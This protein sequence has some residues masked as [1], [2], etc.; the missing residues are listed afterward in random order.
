MDRTCSWPTLSASRQM[1]NTE[2]PR[3]ANRIDSAPCVHGQATPPLE[4]GSTRP[5]IRSVPP[6]M[7]WCRLPSRSNPAHSVPAPIACTHSRLVSK[8]SWNFCSMSWKHRYKRCSISKS[9]G[10]SAFCSTVTQRKVETWTRK[11]DL[12]VTHYSSIL[13]MEHEQACVLCA[14]WRWEHFCMMQ[15]ALMWMTTVSVHKN[16]NALIV[17]KMTGF[18]LDQFSK[19]VLDTAVWVP[20]EELG[21]C[22]K[23]GKRSCSSLNPDDLK[24]ATETS[25][26][27]SLS[28]K[29]SHCCVRWKVVMGISLL[30]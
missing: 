24:T 30:P 16:L 8:Q 3:G 13:Q 17:I 28:T 12:L 20:G 14:R 26:N 9:T 10:P 23:L 19:S 15:R 25:Q 2:H 4:S 5:K 22:K 21:T 1:G 29:Y 27:W 11:S 18:W 7:F 6:Q